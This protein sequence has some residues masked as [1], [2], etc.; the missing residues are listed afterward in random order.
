MVHA[1]M[2]RPVRSRSDRAFAALRDP[3]YR[4]SYSLL[5]N[6]A[7]TTVVG[8]AYWAVA[9]HFYDQK[10]LGRSAALVSALLLVS[11]F[12]QLNLANALPRFI[13]RAG[14]LAGK[15]IAYSYGATS[16][17]A[18]IGGLAFV[19]I[20][21]RLSSQWKFL[22]DSLPLALAFVAAAVVWEV[23]TL[24]D[25]ALLSLRR[26]VMVPMEN[27]VYGVSKLLMLIGVVSLLP[28]TGIFLSWVIP[29]AITVPAVNWLI[30]R[31]YLKGHASVAAPS[32][33][34]VR[35]VVRFA[36]V[37]Y[38]GSVLSQSYGSL[39]PLLVLSTLG[40]AANGGFYIAWTIAAGL[41]LV[42]ANFGTSLLVEGQPLP[43]ESQT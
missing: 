21:P 3:L 35:E 32:E 18:L 37:D 8:V 20:L 11:S 25:I 30:F 31:R 27:S 23:F 4:S 36:S 43:T 1:Q 24:Q 7:S 42:A 22:G 39:L 33:L 26:S 34:R 13:P 16:C 28:S 9:A 6:T 15:F 40:A 41:G 38:V 10:D 5:A 29:L 14:R 19:V 17:A 12:A 2:V